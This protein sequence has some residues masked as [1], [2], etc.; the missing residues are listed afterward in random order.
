M[1]IIL[2]FALIFLTVV[3][4][5]KSQSYISLSFDDPNT[6]VDEVVDYEAINDSLLLKLK[7]NNLTATLFVCG[8]R[9][10]S[11]EG[12]ALIDSWDEQGHAISNHTY[13]HRNYGSSKMS[14]NDFKTDFEKNLRLVNSYSNYKKRF[15][16]P[17]LKEGDTKEKIDSCREFLKSLDYY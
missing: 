10:D 7:R 11:P 4:S 14:F 15:R 3:Y 17:F 1:K 8:K 9:V 2:T 12:K 5:V 16:F 13:D 6:I